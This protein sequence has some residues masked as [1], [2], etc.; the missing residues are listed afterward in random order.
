MAAAGQAQ[1]TGVNY[2]GFVT[3]YFTCHLRLYYLPSIH[4][5]DFG[6]LRR[7]GRMDSW[8]GMI[9]PIAFGYAP[10][11]WAMAHGQTL[12]IT[13]YQ[14]LYS[15][16]G[17]RYGGNM[18][19]DFKLP[20]LRAR[21]PVGADERNGA[22]AEGKIGGSESTVLTQNHLPAHT[23]A[24]RFEPVKGPAT[25]QIAAQAGTLAVTAKLKASK[26]GGAHQVPEASDMLGASSN[27]IAKNYTSTSTDP[28]ELKGLSVD[29]SGAAA[30]PAMTAALTDA[31][32][33]GAVAIEP[34]GRQIPT[35]VDTR[36]PFLAINFI[37]CLQGLYPSRAD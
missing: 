5:I 34:A 8:I 28:V 27:P 13:Q 7:E 20:D 2:P 36:M 22:Y 21:V 25:A 14:S 11:S 4:R 10:R 18:P 12:L 9:F 35:P 26:A 30:I 16:I 1:I 24:A 19:V 3:F 23:H 29:V 37:I 17:T 15:L 6:F 31:V 33:G 32:I